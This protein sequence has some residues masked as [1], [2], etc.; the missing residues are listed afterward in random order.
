MDTS[1]ILHFLSESAY[2]LI[3]LGVFLLISIWKGRQALINIICGLYFALLLTTQ[4]PY[5]DFILG[6]INQPLVVAA[7]KLGIFIVTTIL[8]TL[9]FK[10]V[11]PDEYREGK[12]ETFGKKIM[13][14]VGATVLVMAFSFNVLPVTEFLTPGTPIQALFAPQEYYFWWLLLPVVFLV[15]N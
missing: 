15:I 8:A 12:F 13:L 7:I 5:Y 10:R 11:M 3:V 14:A 2:L 9:L 1:T 4:F 6:E